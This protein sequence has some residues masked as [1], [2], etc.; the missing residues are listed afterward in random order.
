M[1]LIILWLGVT[2]G[3]SAMAEDVWSHGVLGRIS[4]EEGLLV[5]AEYDDGEPMSY[6][7]VEIFD[8]EEKIPFQSGRTDRN[9]RFIFYPDKMGNW[10]VVVN[11]GIGHRLALETNIDKTLNLNKT[12]QQAESIKQ[13]S[14]S[15]YERALMGISIIF[16][17]S[18]IFFWWRGRRIYR[19]N[20]EEI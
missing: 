9:G 1:K 19:R 5:E 15:R 4:S 6:S 2:I 7:S 8:S 11:D 16:G 14:L 12:G 20:K 17:I 10:K 3:L 18:G 13:G